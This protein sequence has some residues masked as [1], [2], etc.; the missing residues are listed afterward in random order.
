MDC[1]ASYL[2]VGG[3]N[4]EAHLLSE[5]VVEQSDC[6]AH[7][8]SSGTLHESGRYPNSIGVEQHRRPWQESRRR[9]S[10]H[11][12]GSPP[13]PFAAA[14]P[15]RL[16]VASRWR[17]KALRSIPRAGG[18]TF[19]YVKSG[20]FVPGLAGCYLTGSRAAV[21]RRRSNPSSNPSR[22]ARRS[23]RSERSRPASR[24][25]AR[26]A[27]DW[28]ATRAPSVAPTPRIPISSG[29]TAIILTLH[30]VK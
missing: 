15:A 23:R 30:D 20:L 2:A 26:M 6:E 9:C 18:G 14:A 8:G 11:T 13:R 27:R 10:S 28:V 12:C 21:S 29:L 7:R 4:L 24:S 19:Y 22:R 17:S 1:K 25:S 3:R 5:Q 16:A